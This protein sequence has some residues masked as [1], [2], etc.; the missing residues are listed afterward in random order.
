MTIQFQPAALAGSIA[1]ALGFTSSVH[2]AEQKVAKASLDTIV[3]TATRSEEKIE[4][5]PARINVIEPT[6]L[7]QSPIAS[8][9]HLLIDDASINMVQTGGHGQQASIFLRGT[10]SDHTL[11]MRDGVRLNTPSQG[12]ASIQFVDTTDLKQ[13][14]ILKGPASVLYGTDAIGGAIQLVSKTPDKTGGF[15]TGEVGENNTYKSIVG[16]DLTENG[17]YAQIRGQRLESDGDIILNNDDR[18]YNY[19]QK[20]YS[21]KVGVDKKHFST[22][23]DYSQNEGNGAYNLNGN[24]VSQDF[25]N[26]IINLKGKAQ[27]SSNIE[28]I[29]HLSQF[30]DDLDQLNKPDFVHNTAREAELYGKWQFTPVQNILAGITHKQ[31][32]A[33]TFSQGEGYEWNGVFY[34]GED[35]FYDKKINST[36]YFAQHQY[37]TDKIQTQVGIR[38]EDNERFGS[39]TVGQGAIRYH[40]TPSTSIYS[41]IG[42]SF[43]APSMNDL[44]ALSWG[45]NP[46]LKPEEGFAY[47]IGLDQ[48]LTDNSALGLSIYRNEVDNLITSKAGKL[49]NVNKSEFTGSELSYKWKANDLFLNA[50]YAYVQ[51]KDADLKE[52][53]QK[54]PR[55]KVTLSTGIQKEVYGLSASVV[56]S[57]KS[58]SWD[59]RYKNPGYATIDLNAYWN[60]TPSVKVFTNIENIGDVQYETEYFGGNGTYYINGGRLASA[61]VTF[62]Y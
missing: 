1:L 46:D 54:R 45:G 25:K 27:I 4:N 14:E 19:D 39:H 52:D 31:M 26:E 48:E 2:A 10:E 9:P 58:K 13:I 37:Q 59:S 41:N 5:V 60:I 8:L 17:F 32:K 21:A 42:S 56:G 12:S 30:K 7:K 18:K 15:I 61:G 43:R 49:V 16:A 44:Y 33:D 36:G 6:K 51:A 20:G 24:L 3:V 35:V 22:S 29:A 47:E 34:P 55:Q 38:V 50:S 62:K 40:L 57:S 23:L 53:L 11:I 28:L